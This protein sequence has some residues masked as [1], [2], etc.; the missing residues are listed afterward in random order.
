MFSFQKNEC[1]N[2][3]IFSPNVMSDKVHFRA[4]NAPTLLYAILHQKN[5][6]QY[7]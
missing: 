6:R 5:L 3:T 7:T 1:H 4:I 2:V